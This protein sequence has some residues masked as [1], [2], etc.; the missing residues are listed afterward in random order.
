MPAP[1]AVTIATLPS[2]FPAISS[3]V[4]SRRPIIV[5]AQSLQRQ[6]VP[7]VIEHEALELLDEHHAGIAPG[8]W[9]LLEQ[10]LR[11]LPGTR[12][13]FVTRQYLIDHAQ[14]QRLLR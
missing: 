14:V 5:R 12:Q 8:E 9:R 1:P 13:K 2:S 10:L 3:S 7:Q 6:P 4:L 11:Q